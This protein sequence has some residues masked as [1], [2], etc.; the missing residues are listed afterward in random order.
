MVTFLI[1]SVLV[2]GIIAIAIYFWQKPAQH[3]EIPELPPPRVTSLFANEEPAQIATAAD[4]RVSAEAATQATQNHEREAKRAAAEEF[5]E[6][7]K[8]SPDRTSTATMLH[9]AAVADDA[10]TY[11]NAVESALNLWQN[12][13]IPDL[14]AAELH[15]LLN[16]EFWLLSS[17]TRSSGAGFVLKRT[18]S[19]AKRELESATNEPNHQRPPVD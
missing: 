10:E 8:H 4:Q 14:S 18:L 11:N 3:T 13:K 12:G 7:W 6:G 19:R 1:T 2:L 16:G 15:S 9:L 5:I 17:R